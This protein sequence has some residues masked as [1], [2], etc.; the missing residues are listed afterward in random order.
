MM[1]VPLMLI[2]RKYT[3]EFSYFFILDVTVCYV[4]FRLSINIKK[5]LLF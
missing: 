4:T 2:N 1:W 5:Y 3:I